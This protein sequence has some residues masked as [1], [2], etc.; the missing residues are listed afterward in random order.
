MYEMI[1]FGNTNS[2]YI[3]ECLKIKYRIPPNPEVL[4]NLLE[5]R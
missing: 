4:K 3:Y 1:I 2:N 5:G